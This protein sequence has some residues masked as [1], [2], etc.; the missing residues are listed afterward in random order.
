MHIVVFDC[1]QINPEDGRVHEMRAQV[2]NSEGRTYEAI[3]AAQQVCLPLSRLK[4]YVPYLAQ[5]A[6]YSLCRCWCL[7][8][9]LAWM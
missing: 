9:W 1:L 8:P 4:G 3:Q 5:L 7:T 2:L 6:S